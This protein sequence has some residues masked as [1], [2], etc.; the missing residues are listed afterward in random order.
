MIRKD[1]KTAGRTLAVME[2]IGNCQHITRKIIK[3][4]D[5]KICKESM[6]FDLNDNS[7]VLLCSDGLSN[8]VDESVIANELNLIDSSIIS[9]L[10]DNANNNGGGDNITAVVLTV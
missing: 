1:N 9:R 8:F 3:E 7:S 6:N 10:I 2:Y 5:F 4:A